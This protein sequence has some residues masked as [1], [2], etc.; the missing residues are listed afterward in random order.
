[1][2]REGETFSCLSVALYTVDQVF[3]FV[4]PLHGELIERQYGLLEVKHVYSDG[5]LL[6]L[7]AL[8]TKQPSLMLNLWSRSVQT[9]IQ[10][11]NKSGS[12]ERVCV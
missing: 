2:F 12:A 7:G 4:L 6:F 1:M 3:R 9:E 8:A 11:N 10:I 5:T